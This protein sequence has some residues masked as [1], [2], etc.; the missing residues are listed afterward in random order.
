[1]LHKKLSSKVALEKKTKYFLESRTYFC[2]LLSFVHKFNLLFNLVNVCNP[3]RESNILEFLYWTDI[4]FYLWGTILYFTTKVFLFATFSISWPI[5]DTKNIL[6]VNSSVFCL[7]HVRRFSKVS[8]A[9]RMIK[10]IIWHKQKLKSVFQIS[11]YWFNQKL[12]Y[13]WRHRNTAL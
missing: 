2:Q 6:Y 11:E 8:H 4:F 13:L 1:M 9:S 5:F 3:W 7:E 12:K 10:F